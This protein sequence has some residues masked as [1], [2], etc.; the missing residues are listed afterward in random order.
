M[1][2]VGTPVVGH[3]Q[4]PPQS[5]S[6]NLQTGF[7][8]LTDLQGSVMFLTEA[9]EWMAVWWRCPRLVSLV[10]R[11]LVRMMEQVKHLGG[12]RLS[13]TSLGRSLGAWI[14]PQSILFA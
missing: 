2:H 3:G 9:F 5:V 4:M 10:P 1:Q 11:H 7:S 14:V 8:V 12:D 13:A 6:E